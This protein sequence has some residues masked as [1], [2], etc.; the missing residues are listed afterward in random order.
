MKIIVSGS[1]KCNELNPFRWVHSRLIIGY[2]FLYTGQFWAK[3]SRRPR[4]FFLAL[5]L[6]VFLMSSVD[7]IQ[8]VVMNTQCC[9]LSFVYCSVCSCYLW[10]ICLC[11]QS[12]SSQLETKLSGMPLS[13]VGKRESLLGK[14]A[15]L[16]DKS[17]TK[18]S[19]PVSVSLDHVSWGTC[20]VA[21]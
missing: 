21:Y 6:S 16:K 1:P 12:E 20:R 10:L 18:T 19:K 5:R 13:T 15:E 14:A 2:H 9:D 3:W 7:S 4:L 17:S 11:V 8:W